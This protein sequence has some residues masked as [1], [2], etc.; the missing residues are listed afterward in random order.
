LA[1]GNGPREPEVI[2]ICRSIARSLRKLWYDSIMKLTI[3]VLKDS[4]SGFKQV[5]YMERFLWIGK[6]TG[7]R[8]FIDRLDILSTYLSLF[9]PMNDEVLK[10][11]SDRQKATILY[12]AFSNFLS[13]SRKLRLTPERILREILG[14]AKSRKPKPQLLGRRGVKVKIIRRVEEKPLF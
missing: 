9:P 2:R 4:R 6:N 12:D 1:E 8:V 13:I 5:I 14:I 11:L 7:I 3:H 10:E